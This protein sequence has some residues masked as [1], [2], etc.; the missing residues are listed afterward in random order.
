[1]PSNPT[2]LR[3]ASVQA[4]FEVF[5]G[6]PDTG[7]HATSMFAYVEKLDSALSKGVPVAFAVDRDLNHGGGEFSSEFNGVIRD[8]LGNWQN[9][10]VPLY[11]RPLFEGQKP[12]AYGVFN[13]HGDFQF[14]CVSKADAEKEADWE[15]DSVHPLFVAPLQAP[16]A[17]SE[18]DFQFLAELVSAMDW[19]AFGNEEKAWAAKLRGDEVLS[20]IRASVAGDGRDEAGWRSIVSAP[21]DGT[22]VDLF[23]DGRRLTNFRWAK[24]KTYWCREDQYVKPYDGEPRWIDDDVEVVLEC[25]P[26]DPS[27]WMPVPAP[28]RSADVPPA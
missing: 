5:A 27:Y 24:P 9:A 16:P 15:G 12:V 2:D 20:S 7:T 25:L 4:A 13:K 3:P 28:P 22:M 14:S 19:G 23:H 11:A 21:R 10:D 26:D 17:V 1:M 18:K 8:H 6:K